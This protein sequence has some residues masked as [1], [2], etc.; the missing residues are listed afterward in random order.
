MI[1]QNVDQTRYLAAVVE[2]SPDLELMA[3]APL[4]IVCFRFRAPHRDDASL[5]KLNQE[6]VLRLHERGIALCSYVTIGDKY[7]LRVGI[8]NHRSRRDDFDVFVGEVIGLGK[9]LLDEGFA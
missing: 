2:A 8:F 7:G 4:N 1:Q 6:L 3:P 5:N 9:S